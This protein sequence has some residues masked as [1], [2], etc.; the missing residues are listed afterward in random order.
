MKN[1][2]MHLIETVLGFLNQNRKLINFMVLMSI[3]LS[4]LPPSIVHLPQLGLDPSWQ[5]VL[6]YAGEKGFKFGEDFIFTYGPLGFLS[7][8]V[9]FEINKTLLLIFDIFIGIQ[10]LCVFRLISQQYHA[11]A[12]ILFGLGYWSMAG[13]HTSHL[14]FTLLFLSLFW[15][16]LYLE[17][18]KWIHL[19]LFS[20]LNSISWFIK[21][22]TGL[23]G[24]FF[25]IVLVFAY[26]FTKKNPNVKDGFVLIFHILFLASLAIYFNIHFGAY[27]SNGLEIVRGYSDAM[28]YLAKPLFIVYGF[29]FCFL[30]S[31]ILF[32]NL[33]TLTGSLYATAVLAVFLLNYFILFKQAFVRAD[34][35]VYT[36][37]QVMPMLS[38]IFMFFS[39]QKFFQKQMGIFTFIA[40]IVGLWVT[41]YHW[42]FNRRCFAI[43]S[44]YCV[45]E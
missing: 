45:V 33:K 22:N 1:G 30:L 15:T 2:F 26:R 16:K 19:I 12:V 24:V 43:R 29:L 23:I 27:V 3:L 8:R 13:L 21:L 7:T 31:I 41:S 42:K 44:I 10:I 39:E 34:Q 36:F 35:H 28:H 11:I 14:N 4:I 37:F 25:S 5:L 20:V 9:D 17:Q 18:N 40:S 32:Q 38:I 6:Q